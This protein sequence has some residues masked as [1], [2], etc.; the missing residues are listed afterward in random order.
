MNNRKVS[1]EREKDN[2][3]R[4]SERKTERERTDWVAEAALTRL[5]SLWSIKG[6][7]INSKT[8]P[9]SY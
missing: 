4:E 7:R 6:L 3:S 2:R 8:T 1:V 9:H 5:N